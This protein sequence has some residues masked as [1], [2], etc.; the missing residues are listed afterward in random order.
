M[1]H[2]KKWCRDYE[3]KMLDSGQE[4]VIVD[5]G[6]QNDDCY[7]TP[8]MYLY[9]MLHD[10][11]PTEKSFNTFMTL[12]REDKEICLRTLTIDIKLKYS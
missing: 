10:E 11:V 3:H 8:Y 9:Q 6:D 7:V 2:G 4:V 12:S 1:Q 5:F